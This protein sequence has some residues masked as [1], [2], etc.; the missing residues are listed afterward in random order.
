M[1]KQFQEVARVIKSHKLNGAVKIKLINYTFNGKTIPAFLYINT[2]NPPLPYFVKNFNATVN[3]ECIVEFEEWNSKE[4]AAKWLKGKSIFI[5]PN[6]SAH[7]SFESIAEESDSLN[8]IGY[9]LFDQNNCLVGQIE[10]VFDIPQ[11]QLVSVSINKQEV[12]IPLHNEL[13]LNINSTSKEIQV[14]ILDGLLNLETAISE[15]E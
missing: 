1:K 15:E 13:I 6:D 4:L 8:L 3:N 2:E 5:D 7:K 12:L 14:E 11:N 9:K 10:D